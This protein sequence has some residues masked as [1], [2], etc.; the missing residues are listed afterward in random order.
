MKFFHLYLK[1]FGVNSVVDT[2]CGFKLM[3]RSAAQ[4]VVPRL[5]VDGWIFDVEMILLAEKMKVSIFEVPVNWKEV[6][7]TKLKIGKDSIKMARD[8]FLLRLRNFLFE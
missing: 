7:G 4:K 5:C 8:L 6:D 2:Q 3:S 1:I